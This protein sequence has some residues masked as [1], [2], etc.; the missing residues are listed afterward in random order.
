METLWST[1]RP[2]REGVYRYR[3]E[4][5]IFSHGV[6]VYLRYNDDNTLSIYDTVKG[7]MTLRKFYDSL[8]GIIIEWLKVA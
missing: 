5:E 8:N 2:S 7:Y 3:K 6:Y 4:G 1:T